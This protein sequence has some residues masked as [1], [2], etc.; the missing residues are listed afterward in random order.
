MSVIQNRKIWYAI[1]LILLLA[2]FISLGIQGF[3]KGIDFTSGNV[4]QIEFEDVIS[5]QQV[6][7]VLDAQG[8]TGYSI[9]AAGDGSDYIIR[10]KEMTEAQNRE[11][12]AAFEEKLGELTVKQNQ[13]VGAVIGRELTRNAIMALAIASVLMIIYISFRFQA[14]YGIVA[15]LALLHDVLVTAGL[16]SIF[17]IEI[18]STFVAAL[19]TIVGYS[20]N[21][22]IVIFDRIRE[23]LS[24]D[25]K[26][27]F[28]VLVDNSIKQTLVRC[29][30]TA[31]TVIFALLALIFLGGATTKLFALALLTGTV[32]GTYSSILISTSLLYDFQTK[33]FA[34][35]KVKHANAR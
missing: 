8:L 32:V 18:D 27:P 30:N 23:N 34:N 14:A 6:E 20:I 26:L 10:T 19:L 4:L 25:K 15:I 5:T 7:A 31:M 3:N 24:F 29:I 28:D 2:G 21:N 22:T 35:F 1:S 33:V 17:Q 13:K 11:L 12:L 16:F 9:Q